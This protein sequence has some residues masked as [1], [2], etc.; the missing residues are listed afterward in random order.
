MKHYDD[1][2][3]ADSDIDKEVAAAYDIKCRS[4][5]M[6]LSSFLTGKRGFA[7]IFIWLWK[8]FFGCYPIWQ[9]KENLDFTESLYV[10]R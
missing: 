3:L 5:I 4:T 7:Y 10:R 6:E 9:A 8:H 1:A 2:I